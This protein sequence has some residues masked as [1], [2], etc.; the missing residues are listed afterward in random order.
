MTFSLTSKTI[1]ATEAANR[2]VGKTSTAVGKSSAGCWDLHS[3]IFGSRFIT[4]HEMVQQVQ[5]GGWS[6]I[7]GK[8]KEE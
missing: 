6:Y 7:V 4:S 5:P 3:S 8:G 1:A 2:R